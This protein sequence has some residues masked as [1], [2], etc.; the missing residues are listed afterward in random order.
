MKHD[1]DGQVGSKDST[2][3]VTVTARPV[4]QGFVHRDSPMCVS[5]NGKVRVGGQGPC[6]IADPRKVRIGG[7]GPIFR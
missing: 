6:Y 1:V 7:Q 2:T 4:T 3:Q 5:N